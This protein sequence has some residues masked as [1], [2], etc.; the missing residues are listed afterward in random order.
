[1]GR[2]GRPLGAIVGV[3]G[4]LGSLVDDMV[5][6]CLLFQCVDRQFCSKLPLPSRLDAHRRRSLGV[7]YESKRRF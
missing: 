3:E 5:R 6:S 2:G 4:V 1:M 7:L